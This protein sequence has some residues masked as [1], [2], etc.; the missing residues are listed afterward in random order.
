MGVDLPA[1]QRPSHPAN[2]GHRAG[3]HRASRRLRKRPGICPMECPLDAQIDLY[4][5]QCIMRTGDPFVLGRPGAGMDAA[6]VVEP[7]FAMRLTAGWIVPSPP[8]TRT[9]QRIDQES[10]RPASC[11]RRRSWSLPSRLNALR[12]NFASAPS[13]RRTSPHRSR[14]RPRP[15][16]GWSSATRGRHRP[17]NRLAL[18]QRAKTCHRAD[19][20]IVPE[21]EAIVHELQE[22]GGNQQIV[23]QHDDPAVRGQH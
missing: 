4:M 12:T 11:R 1:H 16:L 3:A 22:I 20:K 5:A 14:P 10:M 13:L 17:R 6:A 23:F 8:G 15:T 9:T 7:M 21:L 2:R 19:R 18:P